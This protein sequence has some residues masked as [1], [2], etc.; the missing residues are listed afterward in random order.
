MLHQDGNDNVDQDK[1]SGQ[2]EGDE[3]DGRDHSVVAGGAAATV[4]QRVLEEAS[5]HDMSTGIWII[6]QNLVSQSVMKHLNNYWKDC[7]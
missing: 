4:P 2:N 6:L 5:K 7:Q 1:L 3:V